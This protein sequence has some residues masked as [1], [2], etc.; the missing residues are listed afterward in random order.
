L[1]NIND[2]LRKLARH[3]LNRDPAPS[4][5]VLDPNPSKQPKQAVSAATMGKKKVNGRTR[6]CWVDTHGFLLR[7]LVHPAD[8]SDTEGAAWLFAAH[9]Q[10]F[11]QMHEIR[12]D[13]GDKKG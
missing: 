2:T 3:A 13:A 1:I 5:S 12:V 7:L 11:P 8:I 6:Q 10:S 4:I 9:H